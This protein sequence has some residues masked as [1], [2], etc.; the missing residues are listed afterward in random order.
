M[1]KNSLPNITTNFTDWYQDVLT[2]SEMVDQSP[3]RGCVVLR[4]YG[5]AMWENV[6]DILDKEIK[7]R[8]V[9]NAYFPLLIPESFLKKEA[10]HVEGFSPELAV[11]THAGGK[12]LEEP[13]VV[14]PTS[15]TI[16]YHMFARWI[17][18]HR[19]LPFKINQWAN[20]VRWEMRTR[21]FLRTTEFLWQE[22]H[23]AFATR[24]DADMDARAM[25]AMYA[26]VIQNDLA[27]PLTVGTKTPKERFAGGEATYTMEAMMPDGKALQMG[28][29]HLLKQS[30]P[31]SYGV[32]YQ[33]SDGQVKTP[34]CTSW[35]MTTRLIG[36]MVMVH[37]DENG[38]VIPPR[39]APK[40]VVIVPIYR[41]D[42]DRETVMAKAK[43]VKQELEYAHVRVTIDD[44]SDRPGAKFF[45]WELKGAPLRLE[46]GPRDVTNNSVMMARR[47]AVGE[48]KQVISLDDITRTIVNE[49]EVMQTYLFERAQSWQGAYRYQ[50]DKIKDFGQTLADKNGFYETNWCGERVCEDYCAEYKA[51]IRCILEEK[52]ASGVCF[53]CD[54]DA[55]YRVIIAKGY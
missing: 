36:A 45:K 41:N 33:N 18:S 50:A 14:R 48:K 38:L 53:S 39:I 52:Q 34:W 6:R 25:R 2:K 3:T 8:G 4:P 22:G 23:N 51:D 10:D 46:L 43:Q 13:Y 1:S 9:E 47:I 15:E 30:F 55:K 5:F 20:V 29:S 49:L 54:N 11:V 24:D 37:G 7:K 28:T 19:D 17:K 42:E 16:I 31:Q 21:A 27:I 26:D 12:K 35:G 32:Q 40:Q 44:S